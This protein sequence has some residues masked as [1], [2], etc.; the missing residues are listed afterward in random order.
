MTS[1]LAIS[2]LLQI[3]FCALAL[4]PSTQS[5]ISP[6]LDKSYRRGHIANINASV[7]AYLALFIKLIDQ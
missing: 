4:F 5:Y 7:S 3:S 1:G 2:V 6:K